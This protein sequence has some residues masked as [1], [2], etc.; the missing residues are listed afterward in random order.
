MYSLSPI[1]QCLC[2]FRERMTTEDFV[3]FFILAWILEACPKNVLWGLWLGVSCI[4]MMRPL[5]H[6]VVTPC[7]GQ[8]QVEKGGAPSNNS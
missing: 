2:I 8:E 6:Q 3:C 5:P 1:Q 4:H 7:P